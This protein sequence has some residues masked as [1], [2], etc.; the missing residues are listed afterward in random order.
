MMNPPW[1]TG[2]ISVTGCRSVS[3][4]RADAPQGRGLDVSCCWRSAIGCAVDVWVSPPERW[5][6]PAGGYGGRSAIRHSPRQQSSSREHPRWVGI[7]RCF[8][9]GIYT[10]AGRGESAR[11]PGHLDHAILPA[12]RSWIDSTVATSSAATGCM[13]AGER[14]TRRRTDSCPLFAPPVSPGLN[15]QLHLVGVLLLLT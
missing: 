14:Q 6:N 7:Y 4:T 13:K 10:Q 2:P 9:S 8:R 1:C 11:G 12:A 15:E 5:S 3:R